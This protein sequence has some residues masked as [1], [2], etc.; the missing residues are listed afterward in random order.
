MNIVG[1][2]S[3]KLLRVGLVSLWLAAVAFVTSFGTL[4]RVEAI[5]PFQSSNIGIWV[6]H[7]CVYAGGCDNHGEDIV[8]ETDICGKTGHCNGGEIQ[9][10][11]L[12]EDCGLFPGCN[13]CS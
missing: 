9:Y 3:K 8:C 2:T 10:C 4:Q 1:G 11:I 5:C 7:D 13:T 12:Y 6:Y